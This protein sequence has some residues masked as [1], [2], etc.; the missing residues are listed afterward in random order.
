MIG[1][2]GR[3][4]DAAERGGAVSVAHTHL[5]LGATGRLPE[6]VKPGAGVPVSVEFSDGVATG[7]RLVAMPGG[8]IRLEVSAYRTFKGAKIGQK[9]WIL[10]I[11]PEDAAHFRVRA[12]GD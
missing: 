4:R 6:E 7:G 1:F 8:R 11:D 5:Y 3:K 2:K 12:S 10:E 9:S